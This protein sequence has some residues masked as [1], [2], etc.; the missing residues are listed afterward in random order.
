MAVSVLQRPKGFILDTDN[1]V[2]AFAINSSG[3]VRITVSGSH[4]LTTNDSVY[5]KAPIEDYNGFWFVN[6]INSNTFE[7]RRYVGATSQSYINQT[8]LTYYKYVTEHG[9]SCVHLPIM[10]KLSNTLWPTNS[11]DT[12]RTVSSLVDSNGYCSIT[13]SGDIKA[14][15][16]AA[17]LEFVKISGASDSS[18][19]GVYQIITYSSDTSFV[20]DLAYSAAADT[21]ITGATIQ[22]YYNNYHVN[23]RIYGGLDTSHPYTTTKPYELLA[24]VQYTPD[25]NGQVIFSINEILKEHIQCRNNLLLGTLPVN[26][27]FFTQ[28][29]I[30]YAESYDDS[31]GTTVSTFTS[32]YTS[33]KSSFEGYAVNA[34]LPF[35]NVHSGFLSDYLMVSDSSKF[36]TLFDVPILFVTD[37]AYFDISFI[38]PD[39]LNQGVSLVKKY[40][41]DDN[42]LAEDIQGFTSSDNIGVLRIDLSDE[43]IDCEPN[44]TLVTDLSTI[45]GWSNEGVEDRQ[46]LI[47]TYELKSKRYRWALSATAE[48]G[49][50]I[51]IS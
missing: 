6:V 45:G 29:Y 43:S 9:W 2:S 11:A 1:P 7:L 13:A 39:V 26:L 27:D 38:L 18:Y 50:L 48:Q 34:K 30:E 28:F 47:P 41:H 5:V 14:T 8:S 25:S 21:A 32:S 31:D 17:K 40:Y 51:S 20:I 4:G 46:W 12:A 22:Y 3:T 44:A 33:D 23:V 16:S 37:E 49:G 19:N 36:L 24:E 35:K 15:G 42:L 10:Y